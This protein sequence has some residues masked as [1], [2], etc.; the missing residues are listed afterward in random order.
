MDSGFNL[1]ELLNEQFVRNLLR[2]VN[3]QPLPE[4]IPEIKTNP[5]YKSVLSKILPI[6]RDMGGKGLI[7][8]PDMMKLL[9]Y[10][11]ECIHN[12]TQPSI[13]HF[14]LLVEKVMGEV[15]SESI[16]LPTKWECVIVNGDKNNRYVFFS[17]EADA[18]NIANNAFY[19]QIVG[20]TIPLNLVQDT[21]ESS[22]TLRLGSIKVQLIK[23]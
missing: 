13:R 15:L 3:D 19:G 18:K 20:T 17:S 4:P 11:L 16:V 10:I 6:M 5:D 14:Y 1:N 22:Y 12:D 21:N 7:V 2:G 8:T 9:I 23:Q